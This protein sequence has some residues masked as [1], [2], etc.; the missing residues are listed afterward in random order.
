MVF[1]KFRRVPAI[2]E[3]NDELG[4]SPALGQVASHLVLD[5]IEAEFAFVPLRKSHQHGMA[6]RFFR[7]FGRDHIAG[8]AEWLAVQVGIGVGI[9]ETVQEPIEEGTVA[10]R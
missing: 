9:E 4:N 10:N 5:G 6:G 3:T 8:G 1:L 2:C 7:T